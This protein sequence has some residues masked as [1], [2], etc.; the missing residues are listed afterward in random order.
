MHL[1]SVATAVG[2]EGEIKAIKYEI[3]LIFATPENEGVFTHYLRLLFK[4]LGNR[5]GIDCTIIELPKKRC[6][7][8]SNKGFYDGVAARV[9]GL[10]SI[11]YNKLIRIRVSHYTVQ[12][13]VFSRRTRA[14]EANNLAGLIDAAK[15]KNLIVGYL[16]G[17]K[18][19]AELLADLSEKNKIALDLPE[20]AFK[21]LGSGRIDAYL[22]GPGIVN[23]AILKNLRNNTSN[24][25]ELRKI[26]ELFIASESQLFPYVHV[27]HDNLIPMIEEALRSMKAD[28]TLDKLSKAV[29]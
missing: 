2:S 1:I 8:D 17:S 20:Q 11:G 12:H 6:L 25:S 10:D 13:I 19:A 7:S 29:E 23:R 27:K 28:G 18:K 21:M 16:L 26:E 9:I 14:F 24:N 15:R 3:G 22:A 4:E 5:T